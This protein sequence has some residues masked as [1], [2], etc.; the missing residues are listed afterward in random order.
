MMMMTQY[1]PPNTANFA[2]FSAVKIVY[3]C[4]L[5]PVLLFIYYNLFNKKRFIIVFK[6]FVY[7]DI[8]EDTFSFIIQRNSVVM[9]FPVSVLKF[10]PL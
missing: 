8:H 10:C 5:L 2:G 4:S 9:R 3:F 1:F 6:E 7:I